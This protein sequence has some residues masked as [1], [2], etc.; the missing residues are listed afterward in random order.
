MFA[1]LF[2]AGSQ[3]GL[4][5]G[6]TITVKFD[7]ETNVPPIDYVH[8]VQTITT[9]GASVISNAEVQTIVCDATGGSFTVTFDGGLNQ[10]FTAV[11][12]HTHTHPA[13][14]DLQTVVAK[15]TIGLGLQI[16][17]EQCC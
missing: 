12:T 8:E 2:G 3:Q 15:T 4:G 17:P 16:H 5:N 14:C 10:P 6:D 11:D 9:S 7:K 13:N 1:L